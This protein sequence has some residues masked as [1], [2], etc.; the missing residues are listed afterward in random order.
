MSILDL[1]TSRS[2]TLLT[3]GFD[4]SPDGKW[5]ALTQEPTGLLLT[6]PD[7]A[8]MQQYSTPSC[9]DVTWRPAG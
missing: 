8:V 1:K 9:F 4:W 6:T 2:V 7:L 5:L 3:R